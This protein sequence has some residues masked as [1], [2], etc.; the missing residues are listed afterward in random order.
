MKYLN[1]IVLLFIAAMMAI[2][3]RNA[4]VSIEHGVDTITNTNTIKEIRVEQTPVAGGLPKALE[5]SEEKRKMIIR[6]VPTRMAI[7]SIQMAQCRDV[8]Q[9]NLIVQRSQKLCRVPAM[10]KPMQ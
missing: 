2:L 6:M 10:K 9:S 8:R 3:V 1:F 7:L 4:P 5:K